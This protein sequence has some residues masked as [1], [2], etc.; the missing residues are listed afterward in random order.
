MWI[1]A[2]TQVYFSCCCSFGAILTLGSYNDFHRDFVRDC[3]ILAVINSGTSLFGGAVVFSVLGYMSRESGIPI[4]EVAESGPGLAFIAYPKAVSLMPMAPLWAIAFFFML[5]LVGIDSTFVGIEGQF[6][7]TLA[8]F[9][10][11]RD[12]MYV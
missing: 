10:F 4:A 5:I 9:A 8:V 11:S 12:D 1:D 2:G 7:G 3:S 6:E